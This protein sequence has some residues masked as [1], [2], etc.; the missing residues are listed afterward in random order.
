MLSLVGAVVRPVVRLGQSGTLCF[1]SAHHV[2]CRGKHGLTCRKQEGVFPAWHDRWLQHLEK[3]WQSL[4]H[5][6]ALPLGH[7]VLLR[8]FVLHL[9]FTCWMMDRFRGKNPFGQ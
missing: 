9:R 2:P 5:S 8:S 3:A 7:G 1:D 6:A 4:T